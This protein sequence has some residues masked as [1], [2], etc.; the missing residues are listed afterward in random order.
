MLYLFIIICG[1]TILSEYLLC[2]FDF[3]ILPMINFPPLGKL[4]VLLSI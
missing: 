3:E 4:E 1:Y 2:K